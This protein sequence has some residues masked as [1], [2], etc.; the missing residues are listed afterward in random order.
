[1]D[2]IILIK[3]IKPTTVTM[4][5]VIKP[6]Y[7]SLVTFDL[8]ENKL[9]LLDEIPH[10]FTKNYKKDDYI[11]VKINDLDCDIPN[12]CKT[13][14]KFQLEC[15]AYPQE[16]KK[17]FEITLVYYDSGY[18]AT[19]V[20]GLRQ[21]RECGCPTTEVFCDECL[22]SDSEDEEEDDEEDEEDETLTNPPQ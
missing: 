3:S 1:M 12:H 11:D 4:C 20:M 2:F 16:T 17:D 7:T 10:K 5:D 19:Y 6:Y 22:K 14:F 13:V 9:D 21:C 8:L 15:G 18:Y